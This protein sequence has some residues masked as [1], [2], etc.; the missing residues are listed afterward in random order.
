MVSNQFYRIVN[1]LSIF[2]NEL[3]VKCEED[4][5]LTGTGELGSMDAVIKEDDINVCD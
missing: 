1:Q 3:K 5:R 4:I 2:G